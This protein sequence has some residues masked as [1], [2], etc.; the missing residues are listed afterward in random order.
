MFPLRAQVLRRIARPQVHVSCWR[1]ESINGKLVGRRHFSEYRKSRIEGIESKQGAEKGGAPQ[2]FTQNAEA[3]LRNST[4]AIYGV[5][6]NERKEVL[7]R[8]A[9]QQ[10]HV[11]LG[12]DAPLPF[13][14]ENLASTERPRVIFSGNYLGALRGWV[15]L[16]DQHA[17]QNTKLLFSIVDLHAITVRQ[18]PALLKQRRKEMLASLMAVGLESSQSILF[19]QSSVK[20]HAELMWILSCHASMGYLSRMTQ[21]KVCLHTELIAHHAL[22]ET[23]THLRAKCNSPHPP[24]LSTPRLPPTPVKPSNSASSP[25]PSYKPPIS[26]STAQRT[27][28]LAK[29]RPNT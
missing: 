20:A 5:T 24:P 7:E 18:D 25:I 2:S 27:C 28:P 17:N 15:D 23:L 14:T 9:G 19:C 11:G 12:H 13:A 10:D 16:Q 1:Y 6:V 26:S 3:K 22:P 29:T 4:K 8:G 21:W